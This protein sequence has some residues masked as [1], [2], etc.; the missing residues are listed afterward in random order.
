VI[1]LWDKAME[2]QRYT[3]VDS[4]E[5]KGINNKEEM[6]KYWQSLKAPYK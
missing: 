5:A 2:P 6:L 4:M 1:A 3:W